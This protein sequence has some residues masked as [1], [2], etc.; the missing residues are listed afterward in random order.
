METRWPSPTTTLSRPW[1]IKGKQHQKCLQIP[2]GRGQ[3]TTFRSLSPE[4]VAVSTDS[5]PSESA[6]LYQEDNGGKAYK[7]LKKMR[8]MRH[9]FERFLSFAFAEDFSDINRCLGGFLLWC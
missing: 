9:A 7:V 5:T 8:R 4:Y 6:T 1:N 2:W 3:K